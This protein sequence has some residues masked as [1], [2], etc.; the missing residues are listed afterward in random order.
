M[1]IRSQDKLILND[2]SLLSIGR[3]NK[4]RYVI[5]DHDFEYGEYSTQEKALKVLDMIQ[6]HLE[7]LEYKVSGRE[8][9]FQMPQ[10]DEV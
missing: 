8:V 10:E 6:T 1:L 5:Q 2:T 7:N 9:I 4:E 3:I